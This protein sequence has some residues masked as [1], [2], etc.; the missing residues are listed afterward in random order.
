L[1]FYILKNFVVGMLC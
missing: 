1:T